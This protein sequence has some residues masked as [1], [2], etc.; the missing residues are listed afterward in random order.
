MSNEQGFVA[1]ISPKRVLVDILAFIGA[2]VVLSIF[3]DSFLFAIVLAFIGTLLF[4]R[5]P[6]QFP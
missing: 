2:A 3:F 6:L 5:V 1:S 4:S